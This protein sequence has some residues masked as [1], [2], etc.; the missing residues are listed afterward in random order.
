MKTEI[1][2][3]ESAL[4][5]WEQFLDAK[6]WAFRFDAEV[7]KELREDLS[8]HLG[9]ELAEENCE[10]VSRE[11]IEKAI[12]ALG[13]EPE[14]KSTPE[15]KPSTKALLSGFK[16]F[17]VVVF[18]VIMPLGIFT[19]ELLSGFC[20]AVFFDPLTTWFHVILVA[21]VV[22]GNGWLLTK[23]SYRVSAKWRGLISGTSVA[24]SSF[25]ALLFVP[26][27]PLS[28]FATLYF[29]LGL[30]SLTP[31]LNFFATLKIS[32]L[33]RAQADSSWNSWWKRGLIGAVVII[34]ALEVP[35]LWTRVALTRALS[36]KQETSESGVAQLR[37][38]HSK[39]TL[40][41]ACYEGNRGTSMATD[42]SGWIMD[43][44]QLF[45]PPMW[46]ESF[47]DFSSEDTRAIYYRVTGSPY[48]S[49][50]PPNFVAKGSFL[51]SG[52]DAWSDMQWDD[53]L[54]DDQ[55]A[56]RIANLDLVQSRIDGHID[57]NSGLTC[58]EWTMVFRNE[59]RNAKEARMQVLLPDEG[60]VSRVTLWVNGEPREAAF[61]SKSKV[62]AAYQS[63]AVR[64]QRDP[65]LVT[66]TG[67]SRVLV[68]CFPVPANGGEM[69][70]RIGMTAPLKGGRVATPILLEQNFGLNPNLETALWM[71]GPK[72]FSF[73]KEKKSHRDGEGQSIQL[74]IPATAIRNEGSYFYC[75]SQPKTL[76]WC[77]DP[78]AKEG[79]KLLVRKLSSQ[80]KE[81]LSRCLIVIDG[82]QS[83]RPHAAKLL[84]LIAKIPN[85]EEK[86]RVVIADDGVRR[87]E[88]DQ[89]RFQ[90][91]RNNGPALEWALREAR[92]DENTAVVWL[93][94]PQPLAT[95][96]KE[97][98]SQLLERGT[99]EVALYSVALEPGG[100]RIL[101][102][103]F[104]LRAVRMGPRLSQG[105][106]DL[107][108]WLQKLVNGGEEQLTEWSYEEGNQLKKENKVWDQLARWWAAEKVRK[109]TREQSAEEEAIEFAARYQLVTAFSGA[110]V[111]ET[112]QQYRDHGLTP[113]DPT[114]TPE[115]PATPE[116]GTWLLLFVSGVASLTRRKRT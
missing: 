84:D 106:Q 51:R 58:Q 5:R 62:K 9:E 95:Y 114:S 10:L 111:L 30:I 74:K 93:H 28:C 16:K 15:S 6:T 73:R 53:H 19:L 109:G 96:E 26:L 65:V 108:P 32:R 60:V 27:I 8:L 79:K 78:F 41:R 57:A 24:I 88:L 115:I 23:R 61:S 39:K 45:F 107:K 92:G 29:G 72:P 85:A 83:L 71:Q 37:L 22:F 103:L 52:N 3:T 43:G 104:Q 68:Q 34:V 110:V 102:D 21:V 49:Q 70:I 97:T 90:G 55:V 38:F 4:N 64:Q 25:Y 87:T 36:Q 82:S 18:G 67:P 54:G 80:K 14:T 20:G 31:I 98:L 116:P 17:F 13:G 91:G 63:V 46:D 76:A 7:A 2:W 105:T 101:E 48:N 99:Q 33:H 112:A 100:N 47:R 11:R 89:Y 81:G 69:K 35:P 66:A 1:K 59:N 86:I 44:W 77:R 42:T 113:V 50:T 94:G 75:Q 12:A 56:V 40:L